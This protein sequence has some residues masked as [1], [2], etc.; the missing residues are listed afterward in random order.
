MILKGL[1]HG[2]KAI[3]MITV[4][5]LFKGIF[6]LTILLATCFVYN[7]IGAID[8]N[9]IQNLSLIVNIT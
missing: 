8:E 4:N 5:I 1:A 6:A 3:I 2:K 7:S 9:A